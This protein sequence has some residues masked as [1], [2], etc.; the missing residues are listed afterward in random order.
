M[1]N[2]FNKKPSN[3]VEIASILFEFVEQERLFF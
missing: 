3:H 2:T 1:N